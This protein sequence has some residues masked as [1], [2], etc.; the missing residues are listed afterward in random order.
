VLVPQETVQV[1][2]GRTELPDLPSSRTAML[3]QP[4]STQATPYLQ[5]IDQVDPLDYVIQGRF[6]I[7]IIVERRPQRQ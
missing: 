1:A 5:T 4:S 6:E 7:P 3:L 2:V